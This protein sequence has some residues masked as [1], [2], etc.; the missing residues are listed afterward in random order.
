[1]KKLLILLG[2]ALAAGGT[3]LHYNYWSNQSNILKDHMQQLA[4]GSN[5]RFKLTYETIEAG[6]YPFRH[7]VVLKNPC[8][9]L[10]H[11][12]PETSL[13]VSDGCVKGSMTI[14]Y[15]PFAEEK[16]LIVETD[17]DLAI[18]IASD[19]AETEAPFMLSGKLKQEFS[20]EKGAELQRPSD[21]A[22]LLKNLK[23]L[24][25]ES[26][27]LSIKTIEA[28]PKEY[29]KDLT[30]IVEYS[31]RPYDEHSQEVRLSID[32]SA[33]FDDAA[34]TYQP[35]L[36]EFVAKLKNEIKAFN[37]KSGVNQARYDLVAI[38]PDWDAVNDTIERMNKDNYTFADFPAFSVDATHTNKNNFSSG[39]G[40]L[41]VSWTQKPQQPSKFTVKSSVVQDLSKEG[42]AE[43]SSLFQAA[44]Q[45]LIEST[46]PAGEKK[47]LQVYK[48]ER[49]S[50]LDDLFK[51]LP[52]HL[53]VDVNLEVQREAQGRENER[54]QAVLNPFKMDTD[55]GA[56]EVTLDY[57]SEKPFHAKLAFDSLVRI[58]DGFITRYNIL[59]TF[60][61]DGQAFPLVSEKERDLL[62]DILKR[63]SDA[64]LAKTTSFTVQEAED[65][66]IYI[67][68][69][70]DLRALVGELA[71]FFQHLKQ[72]MPP[73]VE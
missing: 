4:A 72:K 30:A 73:S 70:Q 48:K 1:M 47:E 65:G 13:S 61:G 71:F 34:N 26:K 28:E 41:D 52:S 2:V 24:T 46:L 17:G 9:Y 57:S 60:F 66:V 44:T 18:T 21:L 8:F 43:F 67:G 51:G 63:Y 5:E 19:S 53:E 35:P 23:A 50:H 6:G 36:S 45:V 54:Y 38:I 16:N 37:R 11:G 32:S 20:F 42:E 49:A 40:Q 29:V 25:I 59:V 3:Y 27:D 62:L 58:V 22:Y 14:S 55:K 7:E 68:N 31:R 15:Y 12:N 56:V 10:L 39:K 64:G 33:L 69:K